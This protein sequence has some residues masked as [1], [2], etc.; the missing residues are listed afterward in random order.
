MA[1]ANAIEIVTDGGSASASNPPLQVTLWKKNGSVYEQVTDLGGG[2]VSSVAGKTGAVTLTKGDVGL[3]NVSNTADADK[4]VSTE[5]ATALALKRDA[6]DS[7]S[8]AQVDSAIAAAGGGI[9]PR[10]AWSSAATYAKNDLVSD[11]GIAWLAPS[12]IA[13]GGSAPSS[14]TLPSY[15]YLPKGSSTMSVTPGTRTIGYFDVTAAGTIA[16]SF[17]SATG[18]PTA[19]RAVFLSPAG[20]A[21]NMVVNDGSSATLQPGRYYVIFSGDANGTTAPGGNAGTITFSISGTATVSPTGLTPPPGSAWTPI[22]AA[23]T[24]VPRVVALEAR[25]PGS[26]PRSTYSSVITYAPGDL[27]RLAG[28]AFQATRSSTGVTPTA[29]FPFTDD[30]AAGTANATPIA[31]SGLVAE[32][33]TG[34]NGYA[35]AF[36]DAL[37]S[38]TVVVSLPSAGG[39]SRITTAAPAYVSQS[40]SGDQTINVTAGTR[41]FVRMGLA[42]AGVASRVTVTNGTGTIGPPA[43]LPIAADETAALKRVTATGSAIIAATTTVHGVSATAATTQTLP[44]ASAVPAGRVLTVK[45]EGGNAATNSITIAR[46]GS[47][48]VDGGTSAVISSN[49]GVARLYSDGVSKWFLA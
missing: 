19:Y 16:F 32:A 4:P 45:D 35:F 14:V 6:A 21:G 17:T 23:D 12:A 28:V 13:S 47:D 38:G 5:Q 40:N 46:A 48:T 29:I 42:T 24:V 41:Y 37:T 33:V 18:G 3:A 7:Y 39:Y 30:T 8:K 43:W 9:N 20:G 36:F 34:S 44:A 25:K 27:S 10:G 2:A 22:G 1:V 11:G 15:P 31:G 26:N 49:Y